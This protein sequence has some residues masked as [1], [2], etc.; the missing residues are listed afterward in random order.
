MNRASLIKREDGIALIVALGTLLVL[1]ITLTS[2]VFYT[3]SSSR[4]ASR[5]HAGQKA[6]TLAEA[7][8]NNAAAQ[9]AARYPSPH[10]S[11]APGATPACSTSI[12]SGGPVAYLGGDA[13]W[14]SSFCASST[15]AATW[16]VTATGTVANPTGPG[17]SPVTRTVQGKI[18]VSFDPTAPPVWQW[19]YSGTDTTIT[20]SGSFGV[21]IWVG[22]NLSLTSTATIVQPATVVVAGNLSLAQTQTSLG[23][24]T[25]KLSE[26]HVVGTCQYKNFA[27]QNPC[28]ADS[29][30]TP[31]NT[32][33]WAQSFSNTLPDPPLPNPALTSSEWQSRYAISAPTSSSC[34]WTGTTPG[35]LEAGDT[36]LDNSAGTFNLTPAGS[37]YSCTTSSGSIVWNGSKLTLNGTVF[38]DGNVQITTPNNSPA[39]YVGIGNIFASG[40]VSF[41][42]NS[43]LCAK[44]TA[45][46]TSCDTVYGNW[47]PST[48]ML[49]LAAYNCPANS[50]ACPTTGNSVTV[51]AAQFQGGLYGQSGISIGNSSSVQGPLVSA[52]T[53][54]D[55]QQGAARFPPVQ[56]LAPGYPL[57]PFSIGPLYGH[58]G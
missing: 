4:D 20:Q 6:Y 11:G 35:S 23:T 36:T 34:T 24:S 26:V 46:A 43:G 13:S 42:N 1:S 44:L 52:T 51:T 50:T 40:T 25:A 16:T 49:I 56:K 22:G 54:S 27:I 37:T 30:T 53:I 12:L 47:D 15:T 38:I 32:N 7:A 19:V 39:S 3:S 58:S 17:A 10:L 29:T 33:V 41:Q 18:D 2:V 9:I 28:R 55:S 14:S 8:L 31:T 57:D 45:A 48:A 21:P 5:S